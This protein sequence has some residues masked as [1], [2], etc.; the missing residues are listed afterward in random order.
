VIEDS[1]EGSTEENIDIM[2]RTALSRHITQQV[3]VIPYRRFGTWYPS[4]MHGSKVVILEVLIFEDGSKRLYRN[5][6]KELPQVSVSYP[7]QRSSQIMFIASN[8]KE[9]HFNQAV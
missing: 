5:V 9:Q 1:V 2:L 6:G 4:H 3:L 8:N 7:E